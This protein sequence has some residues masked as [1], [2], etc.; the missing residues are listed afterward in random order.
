MTTSCNASN[1]TAR[2]ARRERTPGLDDPRRS[3]GHKTHPMSHPAQAGTLPAT[4][5]SRILIVDD[6]LAI[7][8]VLAQVLVAAGYR[9]ECAPD[10]QAAWE[11]LCSENFDLLVTDH[12]MP[13]LSG[14][15]LLRR[16][17]AGQRDLPVI[18]IS[19]QMPWREA[20]LPALLS[21]GVAVEK[22]FSLVDL[23][24]KMR[25]F[26]KPLPPAEGTAAG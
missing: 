17:R 5:S 9:V 20:D 15:E 2:S 24:S 19:G 21:P 13:R 25:T 14:V 7:R 16:L 1:S 12:A 3:T 4:V 6:E 10:G 8:E 11:A 22:P 23:V 18:L 26:L